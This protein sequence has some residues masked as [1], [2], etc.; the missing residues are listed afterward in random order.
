MAFVV[1]R[2]T[3]E[4]AWG[5]IIPLSENFAL[6]DVASLRSFGGDIIVSF[7]GANGI[8]LAQ[9]CATVQALAAQYQAAIDRYNLTRVDFDIE[10]AA[11]GDAASI[12]LRNKAI[13]H[14]QQTAT[15]KGQPLIV[16][17]TLP[18]L[19]TGLTADGVN[20][21]RN[22]LQNGVDIGVVNVMAMDY[23]GPAVA[24]PNE[25]GQNAIAALNATFNQLQ[26]L[27]GQT[28]TPAELHAMQGVTPMIGLN[29]VQPE[30]FTLA[31]AQ[32]VLQAAENNRIGLISM[33]S[34]GRDQTCPGTPQVSSTCSGIL[35]GQYQFSTTFNPF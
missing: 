21:L 19:P 9:S 24:N 18:V 25:M 5:G 12:D 8:E 23:G 22:A 33:W 35:Q 34:L 30:V 6:A 31:D 2:S 10:G 29:D 20:V 17:Y 15:S 1:A 14:L 7:G 32:T 26:A 13:A 28:K 11:I 27:Y 4:A 3:C 16:Q